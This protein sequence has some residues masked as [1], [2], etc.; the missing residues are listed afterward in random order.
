MSA[1]EAELGQRGSVDNPWVHLHWPGEVSWMPGGLAAVEIPLAT[2][3]LWAQWMAV[4]GV[5]GSS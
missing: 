5:A 1:G 3:S 4:P 2:Q